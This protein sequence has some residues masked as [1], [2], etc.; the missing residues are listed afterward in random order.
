[1]DAEGKEWIVS[2]YKRFGNT[3]YYELV[4]AFRRDCNLPEECK[5]KDGDLKPVHS[6]L[7][8]LDCEG[9]K[10]IGL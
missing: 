4:T 9:W 1:M 2:I 3:K 6:Y 7:D 5:P 10:L 8:V